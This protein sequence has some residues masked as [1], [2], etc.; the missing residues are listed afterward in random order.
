MG[1]GESNESGSGLFL[2]LSGH[3]LV[4]DLLVRRFGHDFPGEQ[5]PF[6]AVGRS[7]NN[8]LG[9][10]IADSRQRG[11]FVFAAEF[12]STKADFFAVVLSFALFGV[13]AG[14][15]PLTDSVL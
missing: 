9:N 12:I 15:V 13:A 11:Q 10:S 7:I 6:R 14:S 1:N 3:D 2:F 8:L 4:S 5:I